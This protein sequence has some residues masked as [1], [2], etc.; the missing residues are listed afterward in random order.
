M[1]MT[2]MLKAK[3][4]TVLPLGAAKKAFRKDPNALNGCLSLA[5]ARFINNLN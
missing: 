5:S 3:K 1:M 4:T 2:V